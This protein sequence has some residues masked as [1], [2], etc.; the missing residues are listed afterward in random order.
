MF[1]LFGTKWVKLFSGPMWSVSQSSQTTSDV[2]ATS[3]AIPTQ[4]LCHNCI[5][6]NPY[7]LLNLSILLLY[8]CQKARVNIPGLS[9]RTLERYIASS[10]ISMGSEVQVSKLHCNSC[11]FQFY[12]HNYY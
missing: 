9:E 3:R 11:C 6:P 2:R 7:F 12:I 5:F 10:G 4:V 8:V 1:C